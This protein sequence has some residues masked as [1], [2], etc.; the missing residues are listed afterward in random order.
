MQVEHTK[1]CT[2][3]SHV[4]NAIAT[5]SF[6]PEIEQW[7]KDP[8]NTHLRSTDNIK[9]LMCCVSRAV[10]PQKLDYL[11]TDSVMT[12]HYWQGEREVFWPEGLRAV[13]KVTKRNGKLEN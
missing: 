11:L 8:S 12:P 2:K 6:L 1:T 9:K 10:Q 4:F 7:W 5:M 3:K 13:R